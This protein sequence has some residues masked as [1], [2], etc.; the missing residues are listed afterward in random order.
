M[1]METTQETR[2]TVEFVYIGRRIGLTKILHYFMNVANHDD[3]PA[4]AKFRPHACPVGT[5]FKIDRN[6]EGSIFTSSARDFSKYEDSESIAKWEIE[7]R[8]AYQKET[9]KKLVARFSKSTAISELAEPLKRVYR[10]LGSHEKE[11]FILALINELKKGS[12]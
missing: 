3:T 7:D 2:T 8:S 6:S 10:K 11:S 5:V 12:W 9:E 1:K 4:Y